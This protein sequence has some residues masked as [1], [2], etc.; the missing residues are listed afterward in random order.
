VAAFF[1]VAVTV[2]RWTVPEPNHDLLVRIQH[3]G[4]T[5]VTAVISVDVEDG[6]V[7]ASARPAAREQYAPRWVL[8]LV[9]PVAQSVR[10]IALGVPLDMAQDATPIRMPVEALRGLSVV[11]GP[12][13]P[14]GYRV[15]PMATD[16]RGVVGG[17]FGMG[18]VGPRVV[19]A[20]QGRVVRIDMPQMELDPYGPVTVVGWVASPKSR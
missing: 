12:V 1:L 7:V 13:A 16:G 10:E 6:A 15:Q 19:I 3:Y 5:P 14:D 2:P 9:D 11:A 18:R 17:L 20:K 8:L 4:P